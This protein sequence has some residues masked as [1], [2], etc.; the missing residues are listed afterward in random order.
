MQLPHSVISNSEKLTHP[1]IHVQLYMVCSKQTRVQCT[2]CV[3][4]RHVYLFCALHTCVPVVCSI[5]MYTCCVQYRYVY[6]V[7]GV[8]ITNMCTWCVQYKYMFNCKWYVTNR[9]MYLVCAIQTSIPDV[10]CACA[11]QESAPG[12]CSIL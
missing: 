5:D 12:M 7:P 3:Q 11:V 2:W 4:Y 8:C 9:Y 1:K 10:Q 6:Q